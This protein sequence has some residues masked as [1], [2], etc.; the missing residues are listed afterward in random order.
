M[1]VY[2]ATPVLNALNDF[3]RAY[4][5]WMDRGSIV[6]EDFSR[7]FG[8]CTSLSNYLYTQGYTKET[9]RE[10]AVMMKE[11]FIAAGLSEQYPFNDYHGKYVQECMYDSTHRNPQRIAWIEARVA[12][13]PPCN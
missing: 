11:S 13:L 5:D 7:R 6:N 8:L 3:Y 9:R 2:E 4:K 1:S 10:A 12:E